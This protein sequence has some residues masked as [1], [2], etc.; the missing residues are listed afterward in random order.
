V[1]SKTTDIRWIYHRALQFYIHPLIPISS[2]KEISTQVE[3]YHGTS[4][5]NRSQHIELRKTLNKKLLR[6]KLFIASQTKQF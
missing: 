6:G 3:I 1:E 4:Y 5:N 2:I